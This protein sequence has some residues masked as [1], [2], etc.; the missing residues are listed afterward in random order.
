MNALL[1]AATMVLL[2]SPA[3]AQG[4]RVV[5][6]TGIGGGAEY[7]AR[8]DASASAMV[9]A[10]RAAGV[11]EANIAYLA[12]DSV[13]GT[14]RATRD[15]VER[16]LRDAVSRAGPDELLFVLLIGH[17]S[18][19]GAESRLNLPGPDI[20]A[21]GISRVLADARSRRVVVVNAASGSGDFVA[22]LAAPGRTVVAA[23]KSSAERNETQFAQ[24]FVAAFAGAGA[25]TDKDG[26]TSVLEAFEYARREVT[27]AYASDNRLLTEHAV[28]DDG[29]DGA[30]ARSLFLGSAG[31]PAGA[32]DPAVAKLLEQK[33]DV[34]RRLAALR[35]RKDSLPAADYDAQLE[36]LLL[37]LAEKDSAIRARGTAR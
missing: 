19:E 11:P 1:A 14:A 5:V 24:Y 12:G 21:A 10:A 23:T 32:S 2:A 31:E 33:R 22:A 36:R 30:V 8:F 28:L 6:V 29:A 17:G 20:T 34:E 18:H 27:R 37:E 13:A 16:T 9:R 7:A 4:G 25:D 26:R 15:N 35:L 3:A